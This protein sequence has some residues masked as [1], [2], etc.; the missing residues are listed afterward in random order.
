MT[1]KF[2]CRPMAEL[3]FFLGLLAAAGNVAG[4]AESEPPFAWV[5]LKIKI[6]AQ[7]RAEEVVVLGA[8]PDYRYES[9]ATSV[10]MSAEFPI[11][12]E[13]GQAV[14]YVGT[15]RIEFPRLEPETHAHK[16]GQADL[17]IRSCRYDY[18]TRVLQSAPAAESAAER[19]EEAARQVEMELIAGNFDSAL[20]KIDGLLA[21]LEP[22]SELYFDLINQKIWT[23][24]RLGQ[25]ESAEAVSAEYLEKVPVPGTWETQYLRVIALAELDRRDEA[26]DLLARYRGTETTEAAA[27]FVWPK[28]RPGRQSRIA[29]GD[30]SDELMAA[31]RNPALRVATPWLAIATET[32]SQIRFCRQPVSGRW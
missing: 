6:S 5:D 31:L 30:R 26:V 21:Q 11:K 22:N 2:I 20:N 19:H 18:A 13:A 12:T 17:L 32:W 23:L 1:R 25:A 29:D 8:V 9:T 27:R 14:P 7:G 24:I 16:L 10:A 15:Q 4:A 3:G 28:F